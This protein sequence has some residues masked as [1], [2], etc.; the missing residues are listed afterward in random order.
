[1]KMASLF[2]VIVGSDDVAFG[3]PSPDMIFEALKKTESKPDEAV[4]VGDSVSDMQ[5][6]KNAK[7]KACIGVLTGFTPR[8]ELEQLADAIVSSVAELYV[9]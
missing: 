2:D 9:L 4:I 1:L 8:K 6:R 5:M 3:K 7:V